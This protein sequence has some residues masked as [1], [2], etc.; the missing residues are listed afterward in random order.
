MGWG[1]GDNLDGPNAVVEAT[2]GSAPT[3]VVELNIA[4]GTSKEHILIALQLFRDKV[5]QSENL[6]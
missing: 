3:D 5:I 1:K 2:G 6:P 4:N